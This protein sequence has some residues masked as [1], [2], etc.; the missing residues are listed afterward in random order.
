MNAMMVIKQ[1]EGE[2]RPNDAR[3]IFKSAIWW[4]QND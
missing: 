1:K 4:L 3:H 2:I